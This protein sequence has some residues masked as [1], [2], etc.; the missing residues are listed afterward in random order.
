MRYFLILALSVFTCL[1]H[2]ENNNSQSRIM[3]D[4]III[5][6][7]EWDA[8]YD[9]P[10]K[11]YNIEEINHTVTC[12]N[13]Q[14][15]I[16][17]I[18]CHIQ[19]MCRVKES[20]I[21]VRCKIYFYYKGKLLNT[22]CIDNNVSLYNGIYYK[23]NPQLVRILIDLTSKSNTIINGHGIKCLFPNGYDSLFTYIQQQRHIITKGCDI[24]RNGRVF[25]VCDIDREG[26]TI[27]AKVTN[28]DNAIPQIVLKRL[29]TL[30][31]NDVKWLPSKERATKEKI[32]LPPFIL[33][34][35]LVD[36]NGLIE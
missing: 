4:S 22:I 16:N 24:K 2:G 6:S 28:K 5:K 3:P 29:E 10:I 26:N 13:N 15:D 31:I 9:V 25:I 8:L 1:L 32:I 11:C 12:I 36:I 30:F 35:S 14:D 20:P 34:K 27:K 17:R 21:D 19:K 23:T 18:F 33:E 7:L